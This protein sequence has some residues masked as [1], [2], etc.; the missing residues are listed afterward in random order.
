MWLSLGS[1]RW[2][3]RAGGARRAHRALRAEARLRD[4]ALPRVDRAAHRTRSCSAPCRHGQRRDGPP[5][6]GRHGPRRRARPRAARRRRAS[7]SSPEPSSPVPVR[8]AA[9]ARATRSRVSICPSPTSRACTA[10]RSMIFLAL[11]A[12]DCGSSRTGTGL[13]GRVQSRRHDCCSSCSSPR[14]ASGTRSTSAT[15]RRCSSASTSPAPP[16]C[17]PRRCGS[18]WACSSAAPSCERSRAV[19]DGAHHDLGTGAIGRPDLTCRADAVPVRPG[20][21]LRRGARRRSGRRSRGPTATGTGGRGCASSTWRATGLAA[22]TVA[23]VVIQAPLPYQLRCT[24][25]VEEA[26]HR[27]A[28][29]RARVD[30]DLDGPARLEL[31]PSE[32]E[33]GRRS[34][35]PGWRGASTCEHRCCARSPPSRVPRCRGRTTASWSAGLEQFETYALEEPGCSTERVGEPRSDRGRGRGRAR[36]AAMR[37]AARPT[38]S[39]C[40]ITRSRACS[41]AALRFWSCSMRQCLKITGTR[42]WSWCDAKS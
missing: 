6:R 20:V 41:A 27:P 39:M 16:R 42:I 10:P 17:G 18:T 21:G 2:R 11:R 32:R 40:L 22:G 31:T 8:T 15:S 24:V 19:A 12:R 1:R 5:H 13:P 37:L 7:C 33:D 25:H 34:P 9:A 29:R 3:V 23:H 30:G 38:R 26:V 35:T 14:P 4:G 28:A 36:R